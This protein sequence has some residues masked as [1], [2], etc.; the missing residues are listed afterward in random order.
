MNEDNL[1]LNKDDLRTENLMLKI[2]N[3]ALKSKDKNNLVTLEMY[4]KL[5]EENIEL[6]EKL[7]EYEHDDYYDY[8]EEDDDINDEEN[9]D[10]ENDKI[11]DLAISL[12]QV[13]RKQ[14]NFLELL[15]DTLSVDDINK[16]EYSTNLRDFLKQ[17][18]PSF[19]YAE[20]KVS[21]FPNIKIE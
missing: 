20:V 9:S 8:L 10:D 4:K 19:Q 6:K 5:M 15:K 21:D 17:D 12:Y 13:L 16:L 1:N 11:W 18:F 3:E 2:E 7:R 14:P